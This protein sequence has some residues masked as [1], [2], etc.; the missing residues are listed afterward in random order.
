VHGGVA[1]RGLVQ[2]TGRGQV[3][4]QTR[5]L[6]EPVARR[7]RLLQCPGP[8]G[9]VGRPLEVGVRGGEVPVPQQCLG[10]TVQQVGRVLQGSEPAHQFE[11]LVEQAERPVPVATPLGEQGQRVQRV[12]HAP[13]V[14]GG[15]EAVERR[16]ELGLGLGHLPAELVLVA[17]AQP[18][19]RL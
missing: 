15:A 16:R 9:E 7:G 11:G 1:Q 18:E 12:G 6:T 5:D 2:F 10:A 13:A 8:G 17:R 4:A 14:S 19:E 3:A